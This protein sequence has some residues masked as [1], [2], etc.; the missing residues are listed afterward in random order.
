MIISLI[1]VPCHC[2]YTFS[3]LNYNSLSYQLQFFLYLYHVLFTRDHHGEIAGRTPAPDGAC[4][5]GSIPNICP[6]WGQDAKIRKSLACYCLLLAVQRLSGRPI[7]S[8]PSAS[9]ARGKTVGKEVT[10]SPIKTPAPPQILGGYTFD[11]ALAWD[12]RVVLNGHYF[13]KLSASCTSPRPLGNGR[14]DRRK[15]RFGKDDHLKPLSW[16]I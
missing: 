8:T 2:K 7:T 15:A 4:K 6:C 3:F 14:D 10:D 13:S 1:L 11:Q 16:A 9:A 12:C 5:L